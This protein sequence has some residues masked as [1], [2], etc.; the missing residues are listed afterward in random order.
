MEMALTMEL[1]ELH[2]KADI[3]IDKIYL[4]ALDILFRMEMTTPGQIMTLKPTFE[5]GAGDIE[6]GGTYPEYRKEAVD[7][8]NLLGAFHRP[9]WDTAYAE[10]RYTFEMYPDEKRLR[11]IVAELEIIRASRRLPEATGPLISPKRKDS[12]W[13]EVEMRLK[14]E[15]EVGV[16]I[17]GESWKTHTMSGMKLNKGS[18][19]DRPGVLWTLLKLLA[20]G[21]GNISWETVGVTASQRDSMQKGVER[22]SKTLK[23]YFG[24]PTPPFE[25]Y[26]KN[27]SYQTR[28]TISDSRPS[29]EE[30]VSSEE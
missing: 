13:P 3:N 5:H 16:R 27:K 29:Q 2:K 19:G 12:D 26:K 30:P 8:L 24:I 15:T 9:P 28:F 20:K 18:K 23:E 17:A 1:L 22:L 4:T 21:N 6:K 10:L 25:P 11:E 7:V 14:S